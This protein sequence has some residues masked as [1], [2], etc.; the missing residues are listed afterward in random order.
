M[1]AITIALIVLDG[2]WVF[3]A[4]IDIDIQAYLIIALVLAPLV[5]GAVVYGALRPDP[6]ISTT[7]IAIAFLLA[8]SASCSLLSYLLLTVAG[9]RI[10]SWLGHI[11]QAMGFNWIAIMA[12]AADH[13]RITAL[14]KLAYVSVIPQTM[15]LAMV[16]GLS[17]K[18]A[19]LYGL[20]LAIAAGALIC[21][22]I[23]ALHPS[24]GAFSVFK[25]PPTMAAKLGLA[26]NEDYGRSLVMLL[27]EGPGF[28][29]PSELRGIV[30]FP[31]FH[32]VQAL[33]L[34]WYAR[35]LPGV[36]WIASGLNLCVILATPIH[37]GHHLV[38]VFG[39]LAV[40]TAAIVLAD[41]TILAVSAWSWQKPLQTDPVA[42]TLETPAMP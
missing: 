3:I 23:W 42:G 25:L 17:G 19:N 8:F 15:L 26:L 5:C 40:G 27:R 41:R 9:S 32:T 6:A 24:F 21:V 29:T 36:R 10:D 30:G 31:S 12:F 7:C 4:G 18:T 20:C 1:A 38:D 2:T 13:E 22:F 28:I 35:K 33:A 16:L 14:L 37:G 34:L 39:G 11:D